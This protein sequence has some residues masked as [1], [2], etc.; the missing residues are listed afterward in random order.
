MKV[1]SIII[2]VLGVIALG[3]WIIVETLT[4]RTNEKSAYN[5][6][7]SNFEKQP[8][9][10]VTTQHSGEVLSKKEEQKGME[11]EE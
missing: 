3:G 10:Y 5:M 11:K 4:D 7:P 9:E 6:H 8:I 1:F 2:I